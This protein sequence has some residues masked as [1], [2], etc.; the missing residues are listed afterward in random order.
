[1]TK[2]ATD[3]PLRVIGTAG[4]V[5]H[6]KSTLIRA[7]TGIDPDRLREERERGMTIDLGFAWLRLADGTDVGIVDV[8]GHQDFIRNML[9]G[10]GSI[11]AVLLVIAADEGVMPQTRE[12]LAILSLLGVERGLVVLNKRDL[13]DDEWAGLVAAEVRA[14]LFGTPLADAPLV[15]VSAATGAG[16]AGLRQALAG[17]LGAV[18]PRRD[19][20]R[21]RLPIDRAFSM[22][23]FGTVVTGTLIDGSFAAGDE[24]GIV[25]G[26]RRAR[27]RGLQ[28]HRRSIDVARP[29]SRVAMNLTGVDKDELAR[30]MVVTR[31]GAQVA[32]SV[33]AARLAMLE[34]ASGP[35]GHDELVKVHVG[36]AEA[37]A[38]VS[39][40][41]G[42]ALEP[43]E[44]AWTQLRLQTPIAVAVGDRLVV[45]RPSP[46][47][48]LGGGSV[49]DIAATRLRRRA[50][51]VAALERR[52]GSL[53][54]GR[55][56]A[57]LDVPR[58]V[59]EAG[60]R[61]G[62]TIAERDAA[63]EALV[64]RGQA[65]RL[66]DSFI[67]RD[68]YEALATRVERTTGLAHRRSPLRP[69]ASREEVRSSLGLAARRFNALV[70]RM[71]EEHR[72]AERGSAL[73]LPSHVVTLGV[74]AEARWS[75]AREALARDPLQPPRPAA[76]ASE[77][78]IDQELLVALAERGDL[79]RVSPDA[80]F[81]PEAVARFAEAVI[82]ALERERTITVARARDLTGSSRKHVLPLLQFLDD[83][84][85]TR[86]V[87]DD[88]VM[89]L[90]PSQARERISA[91]I[92]RREG[93][94]P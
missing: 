74:E 81:L 84:G 44:T 69:G 67:S 21:P 48:T 83:H 29:G 1:M 72:I 80:V 13:V 38:R 46:S 23:G 65:V 77:H 63:V 5:D 56:L 34:S 16:L 4:H 42:S 79:V 88:R 91:L 15:E 6:G 94:T 25:P 85:L 36:T 86:R 47:E 59:Q 8:P 54:E 2:T 51:A 82:A 78:G 53:P 22:A 12:H 52:S 39:L 55:L 92:R 75:R 41:E 28:T 31:P 32:I 24:V 19:L 62:L 18:P 37:M 64:A 30:G 33:V 50:E 10:V 66:A 70:A 76:L 43:G 17:V 9:A 26:D 7:L 35:L 87:G 20:G 11:D 27:V 61:S 90:A 73:A 68:S 14:A 93:P 45:R 40:L 3:T 89:V 71:V 60:E 49:A 57:S 58:T